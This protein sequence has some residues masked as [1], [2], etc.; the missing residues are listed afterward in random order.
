MNIK[1]LIKKN[2]K[3]ILSNI[4]IYIVI[5]ILIFP[6]I[7]D[8]GIGNLDELWNYNF[9]RNIA[10]GLIPYKD[11][12]M[13]Q[14]P[15]L[16]IIAGIILK[17]FSN[18]L[19]VMRILAVILNST[20]IF[21]MYKILEKLNV[22]KKL[23]V[24]SLLVWISITKDYICF[25]YNYMILLVTLIITYI[26]LFNNRTNILKSK[27]RIN[28]IIGLLSG[29]AILFK[30]SI[31]IIICIV[32]LFHKIT[33]I[34][35]RNDLK[36]FIKTFLTRLL[37]VLIPI[38]M[39][40]IYLG[41]NN[42]LLD[43]IDYAVIGISTF[44]NKISYI[45]L[46]NSNNIITKLLSILVPTSL[47]ILYIYSVMKNKMYSNT[48]IAYSIGMFAIVFPISD[49]VHFT[50]GITMGIISLVYVIFKIYTLI[51]TNNKIELKGLI[52]KIEIYIKIFLNT[53]IELILIVY[54]SLTVLNTIMY[55]IQYAK[56]AK[57]YTNLEHF[58]YIK[59]SD[60]QLDM[61]TNVQNYII[62]NTINKV[63]ILDSDAALYMI[64]IDKYNKDYD[65]F[66][67]GNLG[68][69]SEEGQIE[70]ITKMEKN[71]KILIK[72]DNYGRNWQNPNKV[73]KYI[74]NNLEKIGEIEYFDIY[75]K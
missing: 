73:T 35:N 6:I 66:L 4:G 69:K 44:S 19:I 75:V 33:F 36:E 64:P 7:F 32:A 29:T 48:L 34:R 61:I 17:V 24:L 27:C 1:E 2:Y 62:L 40:I 13:V 20:I 38:M 55:S 30:Q 72:N 59:M 25:D 42:A 14:T 37:G 71:T 28:I 15:L 9:A 63:Y 46:I 50:I 39:F 16:P 58:K 53:F 10:N 54:I 60:E 68:S 57:E 70:K 51:K 23:I 67:K 22:N 8:R 74:K 52:K 11:F 12:N 65:M 45:E 41:Y 26:E 5:M 49:E 31:G 47:V 3:K 56:H 18:E 43:F 21:L